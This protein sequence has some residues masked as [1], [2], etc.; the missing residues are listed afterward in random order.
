MRIIKKVDV[1]R[2]FSL[3]EKKKGR[4]IGFVPA[5][6]FLHA[7]HLSLIKKARK[8]NDIVVVSIFVNPTQFLPNE[9]FSAYPK[10]FRRDASICRKESVDVIFY[11]GR[12]DIYPAGFSTYVEEIS[13]SRS[14]CGRS[15]PGHFKGVTTVVAKLFNIVVPDTV[16][17][18]QKDAQQAYIIK[19]MV[20]DLNMPV[21]I[22][23]API[24][25]EPDGLALSSRNKYLTKGRRAEA[26]FIYKA[27]K[28]AEK[29]VT[30]GERSAAKIKAA[31]RYVIEANL[32][33][34]IDYIDI[35]DT[36]NLKP[37]K[38]LKREVLIAVAVKVGKARLIDNIVINLSRQ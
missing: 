34:K 14:L 28:I 24:V 10:D 8:R 38:K 3:D 30:K 4:A 13:L 16:Y 37:L 2:K 33:G 35:V 23:V 1:M 36:E 20:S 7:G 32:R 26:C 18:G 6:G 19:R 29:S 5:M 27:L 21:E 17:F 12:K 11:P 15:R 22:K 9:D 25:R 31:I